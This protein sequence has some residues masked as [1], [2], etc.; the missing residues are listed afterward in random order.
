MYNVSVPNKVNKLYLC[1][2]L[3]KYYFYILC[4]VLYTDLLM[5]MRE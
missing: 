1:L 4:K 2:A 3:G 5:H